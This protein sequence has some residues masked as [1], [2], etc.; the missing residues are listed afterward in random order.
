MIH[1]QEPGIELHKYGFE[2]HVVASVRDETGLLIRLHA[3]IYRNILDP[4]FLAA[5]AHRSRS[6][7]EILCLEGRARQQLAPCRDAVVRRQRRL[8]ADRADRRRQVISYC[9]NLFLSSDADPA[10]GE[11]V[12]ALEFEKFRRR[13]ASGGQHW[14]RRAISGRIRQSL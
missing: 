6:F 3:E 5:G 8:N 10:A 11:H 7:F 13:L 9:R 14:P 4:Y 1:L 2:R 12:A